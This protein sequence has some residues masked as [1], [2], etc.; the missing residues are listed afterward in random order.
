M[1][2][3]VYYGVAILVVYVFYIKVFYGLQVVFAYV[4]VY[5]A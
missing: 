5:L 2:V 1:V 4:N 3:G